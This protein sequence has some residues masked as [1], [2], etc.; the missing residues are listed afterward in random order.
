[1]DVEIKELIKYGNYT[2]VI[3]EHSR[4]VYFTGENTF[5]FDSEAPLK[6]GFIFR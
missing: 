6:E 2:A 1:M 3:P 4:T 5:Y